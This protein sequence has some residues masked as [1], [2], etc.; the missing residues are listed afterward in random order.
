MVEVLTG[1]GCSGCGLFWRSLV[2]SANAVAVVESTRIFLEVKGGGSLG[3]E[4]AWPPKMM[5]IRRSESAGFK[6]RV[7]DEP[8]S[9]NRCGPTHR[10]IPRGGIDQGRPTW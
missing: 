2:E 10:K 8:E 6:H 4:L 1:L 9:N 7:T 3:A 5:Q